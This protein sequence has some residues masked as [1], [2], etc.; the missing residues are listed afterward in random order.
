M[1]AGRNK[2]FGQLPPASSMEARELYYQEGH[3][4]DQIRPKK[5]AKKV[6]KGTETIPKGI[7]VCDR[8]GLSQNG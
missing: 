2:G 7:E 3:I 6:S 1:F 8:V 4:A 5:G